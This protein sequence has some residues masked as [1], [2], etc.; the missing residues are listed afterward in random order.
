VND[1]QYA[2]GTT[3]GFF[4]DGEHGLELT[5]T[6]SDWT[7]TRDSYLTKL[8]LDDASSIEGVMTV[9]GEPVEI[10]PGTYEGEIIVSP[11]P[12]DGVVTTV[13]DLAGE[14]YLLLGDLIK[15]LGF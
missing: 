10:A 12:D 13:T 9:D 4:T 8:T 14:V 1:F 11:L 7:V 3:L 2:S 15:A 6:G 5:L